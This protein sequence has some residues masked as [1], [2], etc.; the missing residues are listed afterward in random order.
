MSHFC[1]EVQNV[2]Q[3]KGSEKFKNEYN[4]CISILFAVLFTKLY[5]IKDN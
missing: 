3:Q 2:M 5:W 4:E 1:F